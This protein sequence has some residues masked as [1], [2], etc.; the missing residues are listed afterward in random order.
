MQ[1]PQYTSDGVRDLMS[2]IARRKL[3]TMSI[4]NMPPLTFLR[5]MPGLDVNLLSGCYSA[6]SVWEQFDPDRM[7]LC[8]PDPQAV[9]PP[10]EAVNVL[11]VTL[12]TN[13]K[14]AAF[15][16]S[17]D[18]AM[19]LTGNYRCVRRDGA[20]SIRDAVHSNLEESRSIYGWVQEVCVRLGASPADL[21]PFGKYADA[22]LGLT[23][24]SSAARALFSGAPNIER[25]DLLVHKIATQFHMQNPL[26]DEIVEI[27]NQRLEV[28]RALR[29]RKAG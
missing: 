14:A 15:A 27:V 24:P 20:R 17:E 25:V 10:E 2:A 13:F 3:P 19:L 4:M 16:R 6:S 18:T 22:A 1:E 21:V 12:P 9:R 29:S 7:T 26:L 23:K 5:R 28:N 8:S 11:Q